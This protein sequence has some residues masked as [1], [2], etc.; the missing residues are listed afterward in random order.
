MF[1]PLHTLTASLASV[2][3]V[4]ATIAI[5]IVSGW[6]LAYL[7]TRRRVFE[8]IFIP[9]IE[10]LESVPAIIFFPVALIFFIENLGGYAGVEA[11]ALFLVFMVT[12]WN[13]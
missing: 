1:S 10:I 2:G 12:A 5:A 9:A 11:A 7:F 8:N 13:I 4:F 3:R 6:L